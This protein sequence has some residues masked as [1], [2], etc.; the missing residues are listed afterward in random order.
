M[1]PV[2]NEASHLAACLRAIAAQTVQPYEVIVVDN[3]STDTTVAVASS[4]AFVR[5]LQEPRQGVVYARDTG[6]AAARGDIIGR[7]DADSLLSPDW[8]AS[9]Q[10]AF[11]ADPSLAAITGAVHYYG[12]A[13][14]RVLNRVDLRI[15]RHLARVLGPDIAMQG[16]N[17]AI[18]RSAW[19]TVS[20][21]LCRT[22]QQHED[23][24]ISIHLARRG[25]RIGFDEQLVV[26][27]DSRRLESN[28]HD[29]RRYVWLSPATYAQHGL[30]SQRHMYPVVF[31]ALAFYVPLK[32]LRQG[33]NTETERFSWQTLRSYSGTARV[34][35]ATFV[36]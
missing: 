21:D 23:F 3:N 13:F 10:R 12:V 31:L 18:S 28:W 2:Y 6:F 7:L 22:G 35:P 25:L 27:I 26:A 8:I 36:D 24:D 17:M 11:V 15:R 34:N 29:F 30:K 9:L 20:L 1:I 32:L 16:A 19:Q 5:V 14:S 4:F 33:F